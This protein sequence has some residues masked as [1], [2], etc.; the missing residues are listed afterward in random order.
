MSPV[1][2]KLKQFRDLRKQAK[3]YKDA[4][5]DEVFVGA[6]S[7]DLVKI[8]IDGTQKVTGVT[9]DPALLNAESKEKLEK[10]IV[11][12]SEDAQKQLQTAMM[13]KVQS[14]ELT[15]PGGQN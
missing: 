1:L 10:N 4:I 5:G 13:K 3:A 12:A 8:T 15:L 7:D 2:S 9:V 11:K 14:G 6:S